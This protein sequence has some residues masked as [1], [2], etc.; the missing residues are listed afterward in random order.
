MCPFAG[1]RTR[2]LAT[3]MGAETT[4]PY[5]Y[6]FNGWSYAIA[7]MQASP[8]SPGQQAVVVLFSLACG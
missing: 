7:V 6:E 1:K 5:W 3:P 8:L 4:S 2:Y